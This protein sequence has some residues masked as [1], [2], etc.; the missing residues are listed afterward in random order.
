[1]GSIVLA[2]DDHFLER[3]RPFVWAAG[4][5]FLLFV[6]HSLSNPTPHGGAKNMSDKEIHGG[7]KIIVKGEKRILGASQGRSAT[8]RGEVTE[9]FSRKLSGTKNNYPKWRI[10]TIK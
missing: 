9:I 6:L 5:S 10:Q 4:F 7:D 2:R 3:L 8:A 1:M